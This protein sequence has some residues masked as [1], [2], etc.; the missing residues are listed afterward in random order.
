[1]RKDDHLDPTSEILESRWKTTWYEMRENL[2]K[3]QVRQRKWYDKNRLPSLQYAVQDQVLLDQRN[4]HTKRPSQK[5][6][7]KKFGLFQVTTKIGHNSY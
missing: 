6:D 5:L 1:M 4:I 2:E 7:H 3:A